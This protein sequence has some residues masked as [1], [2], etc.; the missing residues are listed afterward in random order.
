ME[1]IRKYCDIEDNCKLLKQMQSQYDAVV[2][3]NRSLQTELN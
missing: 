1:S 2:N 3:Q